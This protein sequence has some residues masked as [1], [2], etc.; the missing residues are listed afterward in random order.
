MKTAIL[1]HFLHSS[2]HD[3]Q[4]KIINYSAQ[5]FPTVWGIHPHYMPK[6]LCLYPQ[7]MGMQSGA[8]IE[9]SN[10]TEMKQNILLK[11]C[12]IIWNWNCIKIHEYNKSE[13]NC[14][15]PIYK[16][17][18]F[19]YYYIFT[20]TVCRSTHGVHSNAHRQHPNCHFLYNNKQTV[21][22]SQQKLL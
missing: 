6:I 22:L 11:F 8:E 15:K 20:G 10:S 7:L 2:V 5:Y 19:I 4:V 1:Q 17:K 12:C 18:L 16:Y 3:I 13:K 14:L 9:R 21:L